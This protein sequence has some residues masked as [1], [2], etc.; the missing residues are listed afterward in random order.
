MKTNKR[1]ATSIFYKNVIKYF[2]T[3]T[4]LILL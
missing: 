2:V 1:W 3:I 4:L